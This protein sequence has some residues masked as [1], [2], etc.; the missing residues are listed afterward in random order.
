[1]DES[2]AKGIAV[3]DKH[4]EALHFYLRIQRLQ[5]DCDQLR[6]DFVENVPAIHDIHFPD[7]RRQLSQGLKM[8]NFGV[9][10]QVFAKFPHLACWL[11]AVNLAAVSKYFSECDSA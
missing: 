10:S 3:L 8:C 1:M 2:C 11:H 4:Q 9:L 7:L 6:T 5:V